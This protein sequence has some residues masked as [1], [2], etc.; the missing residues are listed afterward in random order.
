MRIACLLAPDFEDSE[1]R[2]PFDAFTDAG[3]EVTVIGVEEG[4]ELKGKKGQETVLTDVAIDAVTPDQ[5]DA[6]FLP[7]GYSPDQLRADQRMVDFT[8]AFFTTERPVFAVC[9]G[10]QLLLTADVHSG[11]TL[12]AW[13]TVQGDLAKAGANV[14]D[15]EV[16]VDGNLVTS[17]KPDDLEAFSRESLNLLSKV[18]AGA[19][20]GAG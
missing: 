15:Q 6:L 13:Q 17:R 7:G 3:H 19:G 16:V 11:R 2:K 8:R 18:T 4:K 9:H 14:V 5:F 12:T 1:Y 20:A 10:P